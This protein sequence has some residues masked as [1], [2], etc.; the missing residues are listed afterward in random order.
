MHILLTLQ[1]SVDLNPMKYFDVREINALK[2]DAFMI[3]IIILF[4]FQPLI[5]QIMPTVT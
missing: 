5:V 3:R 2:R 1:L 4:D